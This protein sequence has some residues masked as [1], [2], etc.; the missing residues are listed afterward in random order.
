MDF[1]KSSSICN[2]SNIDTSAT[3]DTSIISLPNHTLEDSH[4]LLSDHVKK[5][6]VE[7]ES[8]NQ[9]VENL[10]TKNRNL[11]NELEKSQKIINLYHRARLSGIT[12]QKLKQ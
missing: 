10:K 3:L 4:A 12:E 8:A 11:R 2:I 6:T 9:E 7:L 5:I 1:L